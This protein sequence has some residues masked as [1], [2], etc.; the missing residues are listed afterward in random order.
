V[1]NPGDLI[2]GDCGEGN[3]PT[4]RFCRKCGH[5]LAEAQ[6]AARP[7]W[8]RR[9]LTRRRK[10]PARAGER[11]SRRGGKA[12]KVGEGAQAAGWWVQGGLAWLRRVILVLALAGVAVP[13]VVPSVRTVVRDKATSAYRS[14]RRTVAPRY[15]LV[16]SLAATAKSSVGGHEPDMVRD[17]AKN[18][19]W[20]EN[21]GP[22]NAPD[23]SL[24]FDGPVD[25]AKILITSGAG[26]AAD[27][28]LA[29]P[30]PKDLHIVY[31]TG[32]S[33][34]VTVADT[35]GKAQSFDLKDA[36][37]VSRVDVFIVSQYKSQVGSNPSIAEIEF[38]RKV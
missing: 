9:L 18:T 1:V 24:S 36:K 6:V 19:W 10:A 25:L 38:A 2:C 31:N 30:R 3:V 27:G 37:Q 13:F 15:Q 33:T 32:R 21:G 17:G 29:Q 23:L 5:S 12:R 28:Y 7:P 4:R 35:V 8:W 11:R 34:N 16:N 14:V 26:D 22:A 20:A